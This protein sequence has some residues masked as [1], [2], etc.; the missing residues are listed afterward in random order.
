MESQPRSD[1][2]FDVTGDRMHQTAAILQSSWDGLSKTDLV[3]YVF[4]VDSI[5]HSWLF[6]RVADVVYH[7]GTGA[8]CI[9]KVVMIGRMI[10]QRVTD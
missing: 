10:E 1:Y 6:S 8:K 4:V 2:C 5:P 9:V 7:G 3:D